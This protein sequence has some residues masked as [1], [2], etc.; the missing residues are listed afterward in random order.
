[1]FIVTANPETIMTAE[2]NENFKEALLDENTTIIPD[3]IGIVKG[4][5]ML[6]Y[7]I[8]ET[9]PGVELCTKL[10]E[11]CNQYNKSIFLLGAKKEVI[12]KLVNVLKN[13]Y[14]NAHICGYE[15][16]YLEDRQ[17]VFNKISTLEPDVVLVA[18]GIPDQELLIYKNLNQFNKG[19]FVGVGGSFD[20]LSG[21][22]K[23]APKIFIKLHLEWLYRILKEPKRLK[24][25]FNSN[26]KFLLNIIKAHML[27]IIF[28]ITIFAI[29]VCGFVK[30]VFV[31]KDIN[32]YENRPAY[33]VIK[34][35]TTSFYHG[36]FQDNLELAFSDQIPFSQ[37]MK[38]IYNMSNNLMIKT[39][40]G[41]FFKDIYSNR[42]FYM[43]NYINIFGNEGNLV[44]GP[45]YL[46]YDKESIDL[47]IENINKII[48]NHPNIG[49]YVYYIEKDTDINFENNDKELISQ[50]I[51][52]NLQ[53][54]KEN[55]K[56]FEIN[57][58][59]E[60]KK[61]FYKTDHHWNY[62]G[63]YKGYCEIIE[64]ITQDEPIP[65]LDTVQLKPKLSGSKASSSGY[66]R[67]YSEPFFAYK[68]N[69]PE[70][71]TY[72]NGEKTEY[73]QEEA[74]INNEIDDNISYGSFYGWDDAEIVFDYHNNNKENIL[75]F[76]ES[77]DNAIIEMIASHFNKSYCVDLRAYE[78]DMGHKFEFD[79]YIFENNITKV[80]F[81]GNIDFYVANIFNLEV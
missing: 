68:F 11:Y 18:L 1:M 47:R 20:V 43:G 77:Y 13:N 67:L 29:L 78:M 24:R 17:A 19:I 28:I 21:T 60:F 38:K 6:G 23:R 10:F 37:T 4:A 51:F 30:T 3:G 5:K 32:Y 56:T 58:F 49:F 52:E 7:Q 36:D 64:M 15:N 57:S 39:I 70:H 79:K 45:R 62:R 71:D 34:F 50:Y 66:G 75:I 80:L 44:Y 27:D 40:V 72:I 81:V 22:K 63:S 73:G 8:A 61:Y 31:S 33:K 74:Y 35:S 42:Y 12:E 9:I 65:I 26:V 55:F 53:I 2:Q 25:F 14:P 46:S 59:D 48:N 69:L 16:G 54:N 41:T 76:G